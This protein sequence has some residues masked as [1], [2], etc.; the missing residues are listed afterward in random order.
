MLFENETF[1]SDVHDEV[2]DKLIILVNAWNIFS[3]FLE[4]FPSKLL[5][6]EHLF[7]ISQ[8]KSIT[9]YVNVNNLYPSQTF[10]N[11]MCRRK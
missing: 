9:N 7:S 8:L 10:K 4:L 5:L 3:L 11:I 2:S 6:I 1:I